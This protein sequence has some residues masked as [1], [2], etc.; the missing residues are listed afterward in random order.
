MA[1]LHDRMERDLILKRFSPSTRRNYLLYCRRFAAH[2]RRS[3]EQMGET[4]IRRFLL[5][6]IQIEQVS[7]AT[8]RQ[9]LAALKFLYTVTLDRAWEVERIPFPRHHRKKLPEVLNRD[10]LLG[11]FRAMHS[12]KYRA[13][14]MT[15]YAAG[16]RI[17]EACR[18]RPEDIDSARKVIRIRQG[19]GC[20]ERYTLLPQ[21]LLEM[22]RCYW[23]LYKPQGW[24]FPGGTA[25]GHISPDTVRQVFRKAREAAGLGRWCTP[26]TLRHA[27]ATH[28]LEAGTDLAVL[29]ALLGHASIK[30]TTVYT[31]VGLELL[32]KT[33]SLLDRLPLEE[34]ESAS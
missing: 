11:L 14:M 13:L 16:L 29:Q 19:K 30:T 31:H 18:L 32:Q 7:Y 1:Q 2:Y 21:R 20:K 33:P 24:L 10:Q 17:G 26:H 28:L 3:P 25:D 12:P 6:L 8:Y 9:V 15:C 34:F 27:F 23:R 5:H 22:L 4:E